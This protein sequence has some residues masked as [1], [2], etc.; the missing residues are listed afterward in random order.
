MSKNRLIVVSALLVMFLW[1]GWLGFSNTPTPDSVSV[2]DALS[3]NTEG[4]ARAL[5]PRPFKFPEDHGPHSGYKTEWWYFTGNLFSQHGR[6]FG[7][8]LTLFRVGL[9][10]EQQEIESQWAASEIYMGHFAL[11]DAASKRF[12]SF[13]RFSRK[14]LDL[15]G[16]QAEPFA[17]WLENWR[18]ASKGKAFFPLHLYAEQEGVS[19]SLTLNSHKPIVLQ[20][21]QG[22]SQKSREE[23]NASYYYSLTR[24]PSIGVIT[25][26]GESH[27]VSGSSWLDR[28]WSTSALGKDQAGWDWFS[29]QFDDGRELMFYRLRKKDGSA[30]AYSSGSLVSV[31]GEVTP[32]KMDDVELTVL[33]QWQSEETGVRYPIQWQVVLPGHDLNL[34]VTPVQENQEMNLSVRYWEGAIDVTGQESGQP[35]RGRGYLELAGYGDR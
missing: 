26:N 14:A 17:V 5:I 4:F 23:G 28:E 18:V 15:A 19:V 24:M 31:D 9:V 35:I 32:L 12:Y 8:Q 33:K 13:E 21:N 30:D 6:R 11:T 3:G 1:V 20:G 27:E 22:L 7:Y 25:I 10:A 34:M 29:L 16:A 2:S